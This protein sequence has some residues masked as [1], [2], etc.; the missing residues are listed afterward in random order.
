MLAADSLSTNTALD[1]L[2]SALAWAGS[3]ASARLPTGST[4]FLPLLERYLILTKTPPMTNT[5]LPTN[6]RQRTFGMDFA[7]RM[8]NPAIAAG[9]DWDG[10]GHKQLLSHMCAECFCGCFQL[11]RCA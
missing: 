8:L 10:S 7:G 6:A 4:I 2:P 1:A 11:Q 5:T 3:A 9:L